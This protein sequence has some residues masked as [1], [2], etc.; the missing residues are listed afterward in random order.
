MN[1]LDETDLEILRLLAADARRPYS[2]VADHVGLSPPA[3]SDRVRRLEERGVIDGFT[4]DVDRSQLRA[5][6][7][8]LV[9]ASCDPADGDAVRAAVAALDGVEHVFATV[10]GDVVFHGHPPVERVGPWLRRGLA[11]VPVTNYEVEL[12]EDVEWVVDVGATDF[13]L[14]CAECGNTVTSEG[15]EAT[16]GDERRQFCCPSCRERFESQYEELA[17]GA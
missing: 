11:D 15:V 2:D 16:V 3:V 13:A 4:L 5:G 12:I 1:E 6:V 17:E 8:V 10:D 9:R 7:P 14:S